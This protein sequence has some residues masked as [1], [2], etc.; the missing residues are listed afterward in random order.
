MKVYSLRSYMQTLDEAGLL[1]DY[2]I[3]DETLAVESVT[4][5]SKETQEYTLFACKGAAFRKE[6]LDEAV[7]RGIAAY[8]SEMRYETERPVSFLIVSDIR[9]AMAVAADLFYDR[10]YEKLS[11]IGIT[12]TKGKSTTAFYIRYILDEYL[13]ARGEKPSAIVSSIDIFDGRIMKPARLTTPEA[14][15]LHRHFDNAVQSGIR[16]FEMEV[17]SQAF[18]YQRVEGV[19]FDTGVFLNISEDH[20]SPNEHSDF[21]DY[22]SAKLKL[23]RQCRR[24]VVNLNSDYLDRVLSAA[25]ESQSLATFGCY[26]EADYCGYDIKKAGNEIRFTVKCRNFD[27]EFALTMPGLFNVENALAAIAVCDGYGIPPEIIKKGLYKA[28]S[29]GRMEIFESGSGDKT[30]IVDFAHNKLSFQKLYES[31]LEEYP[32][33]RIITVFGC[34]GDRAVNRRKELGELAGRYSGRIYLTADD[35]GSEAV[36]DISREIEQHTGGADCRLV[37]DRITA[38]REA[39]TDA[40]PGSVV[41]ILGKGSEAYQKI[42]S[43]YIPYKPDSYWAEHFLL[44]EERA[45]PQDSPQG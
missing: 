27:Q 16:F 25:G 28:R 11:L 9:R 30:V 12:G 35:P 40:M 6:Y 19:K 41:L 2:S 37:E 32:G 21:E 4:Y 15:E 7:A 36:S 33:R 18:K 24:A 5:D 3:D 42:G 31:V 23:F 38:I 26:K 17:S 14:F 13:Q 34:P 20:I 10:A 1:T 45:L 43:E 8:M 44:E 29:R 39:I 22:F